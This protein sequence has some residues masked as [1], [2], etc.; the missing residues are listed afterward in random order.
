M[1]H[2]ERQD[3]PDR[4]AGANRE[5]GPEPRDAGGEPERRPFELGRARRA[6]IDTLSAYRAARDPAALAGVFQALADDLPAHWLLAGLLSVSSQ[7]VD[8]LSVSE[9]I[10]PD[11]VLRALSSIDVEDELASLERSWGG[12]GAEEPGGTGAAGDRER[13]RADDLVDEQ[14]IESFPA[15]DPPSSWAGPPEDA[16]A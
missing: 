2:G 10:D 13:N 8:Y 7:L 6:A 3:E 5:G 1:R 9:K 16:G 11:D 4:P 14:G 15:S 12:D